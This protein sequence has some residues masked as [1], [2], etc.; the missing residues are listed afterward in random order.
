VALH[1]SEDGGG[2]DPPP[3]GGGDSDNDSGDDRAKHR[4]EL[5]PYNGFKERV[6]SSNTDA[7]MLRDWSEASIQR[8][9]YFSVPS[10]SLDECC[11]NV[12]QL[13]ENID[14]LF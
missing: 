5:V 7:N 8:Y 10:H 6:E 14:R 12:Y 4:L 2:D 11:F 9:D 13:L 1:A 3:P